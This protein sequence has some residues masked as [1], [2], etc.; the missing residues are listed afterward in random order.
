MSVATPVRSSNPIERD[1]YEIDTALN[2]LGRTAKGRYDT[3]DPAK[4][5][6]QARQLEAA[7]KTFK[8]TCRQD[9]ID[10]KTAA[11]AAKV[12]EAERQEREAAIVAE[13]KA[14]GEAITIPG[15]AAEGL[16]IMA[17][18]AQEDEAEER[19]VRGGVARF[20]RLARK[21]KAA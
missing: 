15:Y 19:A 12:A 7:L 2:V 21:P 16:V 5:L 4:A 3:I 1:F 6:K 20:L 17:K 8:A 11:Q 18:A 13:R 10:R 9:I 14:R